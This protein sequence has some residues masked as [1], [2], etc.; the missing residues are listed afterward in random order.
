MLQKHMHLI[1]WRYWE[2]GA[3]ILFNKQSVNSMI[4]NLSILL[5]NDI[6]KLW[7]RDRITKLESMVIEFQQVLIWKSSKLMQLSVA[8]GIRWFIGFLLEVKADSVG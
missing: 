2:K 7:G 3:R 1:K 6:P 5:S 8:F 4:Y